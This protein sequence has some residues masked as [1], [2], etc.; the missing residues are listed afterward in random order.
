MPKG[1]HPLP[2]PPPAPAPALVQPLRPVP[3]PTATSGDTTAARRKKELER[4]KD[5]ELARIRDAAEER[6]RNKEAEDRLW[7]TNQI[8]NWVGKSLNAESDTDRKREHQ[9]MEE[10]VAA[11]GL[12]DEWVIWK[13]EEYRRLRYRREKGEI[14][15]VQHQVW[16]W[17]LQLGTAYLTDGERAAFEAAVQEARPQAAIDHHR[18]PPTS[19]T[20]TATTHLQHVVIARRAI[21]EEQVTHALCD[22]RTRL[23]EWLDEQGPKSSKAGQNGYVSGLVAADIMHFT[24]H[25][26]LLLNIEGGLT[27]MIRRNGHPHG[28][29]WRPSSQDI[30]VRLKTGRRSRAGQLRQHRAKYN[31][32]QS[33]YSCSP[34][35]TGS[36]SDTDNYTRGVASSATDQHG[37]HSDANQPDSRNGGTS[38]NASSSS[39]SSSSSNSS[40]STD[41]RDS[42]IDSN[43]NSNAG[44]AAGPMAL[45][46]TPQAPPNK[47]RA[48]GDGDSE[49]AKKRQRGAKSRNKRGDARRR[50]RKEK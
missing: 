9:T 14:T 35:D 21:T 38:T 28:L 27:G 22:T 11:K 31:L 2:P 26:Q 13:A 50:G 47:H 32:T 34:S 7:L 6:A 29:H 37:T 30:R 4:K 43:S 17:D 3:P 15:A 24:R 49:P 25:A 48:S 33:A 5:R 36:S 16:S 45:Q 20:D 39:S 1:K 41:N 40:G 23:I 19:M 44:A 46:P 8:W 10:M 12:T 42:T 18:E